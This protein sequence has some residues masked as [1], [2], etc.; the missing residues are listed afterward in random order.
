MLSLALCWRRLVRM[1]SLDQVGGDPSRV[2]YGTDT[3]AGVILFG[4]VLGA[5]SAGMLIVRRR[6]SRTIVVVS[7]MP[8]LLALGAAFVTASVTS[9][10]LYE[11]GYGVIALAIVLSCCWRPPSPGRNPLRKEFKTVA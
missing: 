6:A 3:H 9:S 11:G 10:W 7:W 4:A 5:L 8:P 1:A 2:Y